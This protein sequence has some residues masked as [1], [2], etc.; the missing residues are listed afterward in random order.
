MTSEQQVTEL[1]KLIQESVLG[2]SEYWAQKIADYLVQHGV[3]VPAEP[4]KW[5]AVKARRPK[6]ETEV[7]CWNKRTGFWVGGILSDGRWVLEKPSHWMP[8]PVA[9]RILRITPSNKKGGAGT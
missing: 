6:P 2:C 7:L 9:P 1:T 8:L 3:I 5:I 4:L